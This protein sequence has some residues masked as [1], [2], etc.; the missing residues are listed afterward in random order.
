MDNIVAIFLF[1]FSSTLTPGPNNLMIMNSGLNYGLKKSMPHYLGIC[2]GFPLMVMIVGLGFGAVFT[3]YAWIKSVLKWLG[4]IYMLYLAWRI[5]V[6]VVHVNDSA[7]TAP[8]SFWEAA[9]FQWVNPKAW[10]MAV[11]TISLFTFSTHP[12]S[13][14][15]IITFIFLLV[16]LPCIGIWL[17]FGTV[18]QRILKEEKHQR[19]FNYLMATALA[20]SV[21][22]MVFE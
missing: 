12:F 19:W 7:R 6:S 1:T 18:L 2:L 13:N 20:A 3:Q 17:V 4:A 16:C 15:A 14:A 10:I 21:V 22:M 5:A 11:S 9:T 8:L